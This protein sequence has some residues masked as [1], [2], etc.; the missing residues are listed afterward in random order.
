MTEALVRGKELEYNRLLEQHDAI[1]QDMFGTLKQ[2]QLDGD[3]DEGNFDPV[4]PAQVIDYDF[5]HHRKPTMGVRRVISDVLYDL[6]FLQRGGIPSRCMASN[7][8][9]PR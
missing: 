3:D 1:N 7:A 2:A 8:G 4:L 6:V 9:T 5:D